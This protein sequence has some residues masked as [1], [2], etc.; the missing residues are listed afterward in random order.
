MFQPEKCKP[1]VLERFWSKVDRSGTCWT[2]E[3]AKHKDGYGFFTP[4]HGKLMLAHRFI[5][6]ALNGPHKEGEQTL[7]ICDNPACVRPSHL[8]RGTQRDNVLDM[9]RK[10]RSMRAGERNPNSRL[11]ERDVHDIRRRRHDGQTYAIIAKHYGVKSR[12]VHDIIAR[13]TWRNT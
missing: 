6:H 5:D 7:H 13:K 2:W 4:Y 1:N 12:T 3:A 11:T 8:F 10:G 9:Y